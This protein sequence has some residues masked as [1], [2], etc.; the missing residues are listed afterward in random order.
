MTERRAVSGKGAYW[1]A[2]PGNLSAYL[3]CKAREILEKHSDH[4]IVVFEVLNA[5][6]RRDVVPLTVTGSP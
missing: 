4:A 2:G 3:E 1:R 5:M 6:L